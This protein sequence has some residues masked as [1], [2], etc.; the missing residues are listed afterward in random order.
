MNNLIYF[1]KSFFEILKKYQSTILRWLIAAILLKDGFSQIFS[2]LIYLSEIQLNLSTP[3]LNLLLVISTGVLFVILSTLLL[4]GLNTRL[5]PIFLGLTYLFHLYATH[6]SLTNFQDL[7][8]L[9]LILLCLISQTETTLDHQ[10]QNKFPKPSVPQTNTTT[11][12]VTS[13]VVT[14]ETPHP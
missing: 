3:N 4:L 2:P 7:G 10:L 8:G 14:N 9:I 13:P 12:P 11:A 1:T 6:A 5:T